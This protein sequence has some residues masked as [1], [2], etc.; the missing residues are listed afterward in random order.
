[1]DRRS[2]IKNAGLAGA[3]AAAASALA[4]PALAQSAPKL[5]WRLTSSFPKSLDALI[6]AA[7][8][9]SQAVSE[10]TDGNFTV[11]VFAGGEIVPPLQALDAV[12]DGTVEMA[13]SASY[14]YWGKDPTFAFGTAVPFGLNARQQNAWMYYGGGMDLMNEFYKNYKVIAFPGGNTGAQMGGWFRKE[15]NNLDDL[16]GLKMRIAGFAGAVMAKLGAVPT[17]IA[18]GD[19][20]PS[21]E[22]GT[23]DA[24]EFVGPYDDE[25]LGFYK[26]AKYY[27]YPGWWEGGAMLHFFVGLDK[28]NSLPKAY[29]SV[30]QTAA[31]MA[32]TKMLADYD[33]KNPPALRRLVENGA[34]LRAFSA[35]ILEASFNAANQT[36]D[37]IGAKNENFKKIYEAMKAYRGPEFL[38]EQVTDGTYDSFMM[39]MQRQG[40]L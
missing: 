4:A 22:K 32:N 1:M 18:A 15:V 33:D 17:Q 14:Y 21:L 7:Q 6:G 39:A 9:F 31:A 35:E 23:I 25:K 11:Q 16:K 20:Y 19:I 30:V 40:K 8:N 34:V 38:W 37:E 28:W 36:F 13:Q 26:V 3:G 5:T 10:M 27:Y 24:V 2:F 12:T 29:Q